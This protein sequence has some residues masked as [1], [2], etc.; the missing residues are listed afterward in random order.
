MINLN[1]KTEIVIETKFLLRIKIRLS[2]KNISVKFLY[3]SRRSAKPLS[4]R[5]VVRRMEEVDR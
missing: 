5:F 2:N 3:L 1:D 4:I